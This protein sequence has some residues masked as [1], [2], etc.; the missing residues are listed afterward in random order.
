[1]VGRLATLMIDQTPS[2]YRR[3]AGLS[4]SVERVINIGLLDEL[5]DEQIRQQLAAR[6]G[7]TP[8]CACLADGV[9]LTLSAAHVAQL[10]Q[11]KINQLDNDGVGVI[12]LHGCEDF[13]G[14]SAR[15]ALLVESGRLLPP[16]INGIVA[17]CKVGILVPVARH[18]QQQVRRWSYLAEPPCFAVAS[19]WLDS[20]DEFAAAARSLCRQGATVLLLDYPGYGEHH[21]DF[22]RSLLDIPV[23]LA[24]SL[25]LRQAEAL[26]Y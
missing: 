7:D 11:H 15:Q 2:R 1:M 19:P 8:F 13:S 3:P 9:S 4:Q 22:L 23:L 10:L 21:K 25:A 17:Q 20:M 24:H 26:A 14:L 5:S 18:I 6:D 16:L 12:L